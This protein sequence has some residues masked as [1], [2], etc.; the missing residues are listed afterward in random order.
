MISSGHRMPSGG[1][2]H[3]VPQKKPAKIL[4]VDFSDQALLA[5]IAKGDLRA[6][7][8]LITL[9]ENRVPRAEKILQEL[10]KSTGKAH[11]IGVTGSPGA[12]KS[13]LVDQLAKKWHEKG[14]RVGI[15]AVDPSSP[16]SGGAV[17]GDRIRMSNASAVPGVFIRSMATRGALGG[18]SRATFDAVQIL[19]AAG[20]DC[21]LIETV[22]VGQGE[23]DVVRI[24]DTCIVVLVPGMGD[25]VQAFKAGI[26][27]IADLYAINKADREGA[28]LLERDLMTLLSI[29]ET[30]PGDW[31]PLLQRTVATSGDG[32][33]ELLEKLAA[34]EKWLSSSAQ[35]KER[36]RRVLEYTIVRLACDLVLSGSFDSKDSVLQS[37]VQKCMEREID[38]HSAAQKLLQETMRRK[39]GGSKKR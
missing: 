31:E 33:D 26:L 25:S 5:G 16:F 13:T 15:V 2:F 18:L 14:K 9:S 28:D 29:G 39:T 17:L 1:R 11:I 32:T 34:H 23:V 36:R 20:F 3:D 37:L 7:A 38:P 10:Y 19:D 6:V 24:A 30:R 8:R 27:E 4:D 22:G 21:I 12:G 35:G